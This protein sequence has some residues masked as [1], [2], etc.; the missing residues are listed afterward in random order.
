LN[1]RPLFRDYKLWGLVG[2]P[3]IQPTIPSGEDFIL[4]TYPV[5]NK[6]FSF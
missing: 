6:L 5:D 2:N 3:C 1:R 4:Q